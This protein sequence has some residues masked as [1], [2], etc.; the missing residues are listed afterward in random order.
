MGPT[1]DQGR[2]AQRRNNIESVNNVTRKDNLITRGR[3][4]FFLSTS[5]ATHLYRRSD[6][7]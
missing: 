6:C 4:E 7:S 5:F 1:L 3:Y 2:V